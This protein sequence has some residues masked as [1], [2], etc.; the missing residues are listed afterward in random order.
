[1]CVELFKRVEDI[2]LEDL[3]KRFTGALVFS[4][5]LVDT[6]ITD[7]GFKYLDISIV[8]DGDQKLL[9][10]EWYAS[11]IPRIWLKLEE[12]DIEGF[13]STSLIEKSEWQSYNRRRKVAAQ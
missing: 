1:M 11:F 3:N 7:D 2:V 9:D 10:P 8:F 6:Y 4:P 12:A 13:P 5:I